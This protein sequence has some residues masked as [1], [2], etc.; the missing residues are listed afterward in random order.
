[1]KLAVVNRTLNVIA[2]EVVIL[3]FIFFSYF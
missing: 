3:C 1:V 2:I